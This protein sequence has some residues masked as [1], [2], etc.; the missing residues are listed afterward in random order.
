MTASVLF[1]DSSFT[2]LSKNHLPVAEQVK[3]RFQVTF[4]SVCTASNVDSQKE[5]E[6][7]S[8]LSEVGSI[9]KMRCTPKNIEKLFSETRP[10]Y[11]IFGGFRPFDVL[12]IAMC[13]QRDISTLVFQHGLEIDHVYY[14]F[15]ELFRFL[16][17]VLDYVAIHYHYAR[18]T[19]SG[20]VL[21]LYSYF[22]YM[23]FGRGSA[24]TI[25]GLKWS[26]PSLFITYSDYYRRF[27][28]K[29]FGLPP[30]IFK[31][32]RGSDLELLDVDLH[33][34]D[35]VVVYFA[36]TLVEDGR[37]RKDQ[38]ANV[39][40]VINSLA[41]SGYNVVIKLHPRS[42]L[43]LYDSLTGAIKLTRSMPKGNVFI[44]HY[45]SICFPVFLKSGRLV[46]WNL[47]GHRLPEIF[48][49]MAK[50]CADNDLELRGHI[51]A[52]IDGRSEPDCPEARKA[53]ARDFISIDAP[54]YVEILTMELKSNEN[55]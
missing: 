24:Q 51:A 22:R 25:M 54:S 52:L 26:R 30:Q 53:T 46:F 49:F 8:K 1:V 5:I 9:R 31:N 10:G 38:F 28:S 42:D 16:P 48:S 55:V 36:Q 27:W 43:R 35:P 23:I 7:E 32:S 19:G 34:D 21:P 11:C 3:H 50:F 40:S 44:T 15:S 4:V 14:N 18:V 12:F 39:L 41:M 45:S 29:K 20:I 2:M 37:M 33:T 13:R 47:R 6:A 17:K